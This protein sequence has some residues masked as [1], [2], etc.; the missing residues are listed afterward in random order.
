[1]KRGIVVMYKFFWLPFFFFIELRKSLKFIAWN[2]KKHRLKMQRFLDNKVNGISL[3]F[4]FN[5]KNLELILVCG[6]RFERN[7]HIN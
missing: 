7:L 3:K 6:L 5:V 2:E 1:M 4:S